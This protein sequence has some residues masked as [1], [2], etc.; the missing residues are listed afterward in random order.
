MSREGGL[1]TTSCSHRGNHSTV[2][3]ALHNPHPHSH[4]HPHPH[5]HPRHLGR[6]LPR[7]GDKPP[8]LSPLASVR[9]EIARRSGG[10]TFEDAQGLIQVYG[11]AREE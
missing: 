1:E 7:S 5:P 2:K 8:T 11:L 9:L 6:N 4:S 10:R 3:D